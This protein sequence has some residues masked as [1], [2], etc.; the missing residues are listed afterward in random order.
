MSLVEIAN[1]L[2]ATGSWFSGIAVALSVFFLWKQLRGLRYSIESSSYHQVQNLMIDIDRFFINNIEIVKYFRNNIDVVGSDEN[3]QKLLLIAEM[4]IDHFDNVYHQRGTLPHGTY[5]GFVAYM[6]E[7]YKNS[8]IVRHFI[9]QR[10][11]WYNPDFIALFELP[12]ENGMER[13]ASNT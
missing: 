5:D 4:L 6:Q 10:K 8:P 9:S 1:W 12:Q 13:I 3:R 7:T 11:S 2:S